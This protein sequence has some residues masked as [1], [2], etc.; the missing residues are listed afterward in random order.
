MKNLLLSIVGG[1]ALSGCVGVLHTNESV[2]QE[3]DSNWDLYSDTWVATDALGRTMPGIEKVG[4]VKDDKKRTVGFF[5][6]AWLSDNLAT[7][8]AP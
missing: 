1:F 6:I 2:Q 8:N 7:L 5:Y 4:P 3:T